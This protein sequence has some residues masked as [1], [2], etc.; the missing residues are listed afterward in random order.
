MSKKS[1]KRFL[2]RL[3]YS[4]KRARVKITKFDR[5]TF[6][7][8]E[9]EIE[10]L[11]EETTKNKNAE[12]YFFDENSFSLTPNI[13]YGWSLKNETILLEGTRFKSLKALGGF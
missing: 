2:K 7:K 6:D 4:Y 3:G 10:Y 13:P 1:L 12:L 8:A 5:E 11:K 9:E